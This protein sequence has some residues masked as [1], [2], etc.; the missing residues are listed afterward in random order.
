MNTKAY[1]IELSKE[2]S[3]V[4]QFTSFVAIEKREEGEVVAEDAPT[5]EELVEKEAVDELAYMGYEKVHTSIVRHAQ[6]Q[7]VD[8]RYGHPLENHKYIGFLSNTDPDLLKITKLS[9]QHS[10]LGCHRHASERPF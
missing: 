1:I 5:M 6:I 3:I 9:S 2:Y 7:R 10:M 8:R 4:T